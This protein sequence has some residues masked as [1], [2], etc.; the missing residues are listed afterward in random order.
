MK[1]KR[2]RIKREKNYNASKL[3]LKE[4]AEIR[5]QAGM[6]QHYLAAKYGVCQQT[7]CQILKRKTW[8]GVGGVKHYGKELILDLFECNNEL[9]TRN[10][11]IEYF[12]IL[13][14]MIGMQREKLVFW[15]DHN[16]PVKERQT[17][18][19]TKGTT[20]VQFILTS[21]ITIHTLDLTSSVYINI[22]SCKD[23]DHILAKK[24]SMDYFECKNLIQ[25]NMIIRG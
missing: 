17:L 5:G 6:K 3:T 4:V 21:N 19:H 22:F 9:F 15:D 16:V 20:A 8:K 13:C 2:L 25:S 14:G 18:D 7:I 10:K 12:E 11:L 1:E 23:F 24:F